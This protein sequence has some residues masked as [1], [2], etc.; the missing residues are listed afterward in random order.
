MDLKIN[1]ILSHFIPS[2][3]IPSYHILTTLLLRLVKGDL[4]LKLKIIHVRMLF[5]VPLAGK[6]SLRSIS[7]EPSKES[8]ILSGNEE[9]KFSFASVQ[10]HL[11]W[12][13]LTAGT[14]VAT[15]QKSRQLR[16]LGLFQN[17]VS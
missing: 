15:K 17:Q 16:V 12:H 9:A 6:H 4:T 8:N 13:L 11:E 14:Y 2:H 10:A 1:T 7:I 3:P 5:L